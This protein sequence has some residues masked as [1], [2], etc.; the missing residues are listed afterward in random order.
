[1][2]VAVVRVGCQCAEV[3]GRE[4]ASADLLDGFFVNDGFAENL[5]VLHKKGF[6][7]AGCKV[8]G[9]RLQKI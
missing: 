1:V 2:A 8:S 3:V 4:S 9:L 6:K 5:E 7:V